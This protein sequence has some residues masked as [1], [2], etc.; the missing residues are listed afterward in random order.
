MNPEE[1]SIIVPVSIETSA[2]KL[3]PVETTQPPNPTEGAPVPTAT[4]EASQLAAASAEPTAPTTTIPEETQASPEP[5]NPLT[6][7]FTTQEWIVLKE[8]RVTQTYSQ[9]YTSPLTSIQ[10]ALPEILAQA[11]PD[12][13]KAKETPFSM[14]GVKIDPNNPRDAKISVVL[15]KFLRAR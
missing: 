12:N 1:V 2:K 14:W 15:M 11:F 7:R 9:L 6:E 5:Q 13:P 4:T 10:D 3:T 8:F